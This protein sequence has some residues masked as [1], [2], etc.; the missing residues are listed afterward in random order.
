MGIETS[1]VIT[2]GN[3][4]KILSLAFNFAARIINVSWEV[5]N[6]ITRMIVVINQMKKDV[7]IIINV[8]KVS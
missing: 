1:P 7:A 4:Y 3:N 8:T 5:A 6:V 2:K